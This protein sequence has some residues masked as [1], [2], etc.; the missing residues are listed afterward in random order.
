MK[1]LHQFG[2]TL[3]HSSAA[4]PLA[5][6][7]ALEAVAPVQVIEPAAIRGPPGLRGKGVF[8]SDRNPF[9]RQ[10]VFAEGRNQDLPAIESLVD[11]ERHPTSVRRESRGTNRMVRMTQEIPPFFPAHP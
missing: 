1:M 6:P 7:N 5:R 10:S 2:L 9:F 4:I 3:R 8:R 11:F